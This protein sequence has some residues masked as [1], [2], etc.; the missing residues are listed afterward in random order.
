MAL[1]MSC[2]WAQMSKVRIIATVAASAGPNG[3][4]MMLSALRPGLRRLDSR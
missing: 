2:S 4:G 3:P 1:R